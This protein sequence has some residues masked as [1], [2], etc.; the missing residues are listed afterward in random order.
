M[1]SWKKAILLAEKK[2]K[3]LFKFW[4][5]G[6]KIF[7]GTETTYLVIF[8]CLKCKYLVIIAHKRHEK[9]QHFS[10]KLKRLKMSK[11]ALFL[12]KIFFK[13]S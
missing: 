11:N 10:L 1:L 3:N 4:P 2:T 9:Q 12:S 6:K 8:L 5:N 13:V 7:G